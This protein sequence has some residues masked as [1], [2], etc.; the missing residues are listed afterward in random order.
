MSTVPLPSET[1]P[2]T[3]ILLANLGTPAAPEARPVGRFLREFLSDPRVV[4]LPRW[5]WLPLLN[6]V[7]VPLRSRRSAEAYRKVWTDE[8]SPLLVFTLRLA[9]KLSHHLSGK[10]VVSAGMRYG[11]PSIAAAL[12]EFHSQGIQKLVVLPLYPQYSGTTTPSVFDAVDV[13]LQSMNWQPEQH[14][15]EHYYQHPQWVSA[16]ADSITAFQSK[17]GTADMVLFSLH[18]IPE[19]YVQNGDPYAQ[20]CRDCIAAIAQKAGLAEGKWLLT[21]QSRVGREPWLQPYT[22]QILEELPKQGVQHVQVVCPGFAVDCLETLEE[23]AMQNRELFE[24][25]GGK[26][27]KYIPAL[28]DTDTHVEVMASLVEQFIP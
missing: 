1:G 15:V 7:I 13:A 24:E 5:L 9:K 22:D 17:H 16:V 6:L 19:R 8:G 2:K 18:G 10:A 4:D 3:A 28:N 27:L 21:F 14:R 11:E 26:S 12:A 25:S 20:Q 23:I